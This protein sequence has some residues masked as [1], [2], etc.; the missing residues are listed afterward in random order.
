MLFRCLEVVEA[1]LQDD[2]VAAVD[3]VDVAVFVADPAGPAAGQC[4]AQ[5]FRFAG[6]SERLAGDLVEEPV[7]PFELRSVRC[8]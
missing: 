8:H 6:T 4:V 3:E 7:D 5:L 1:G 2:H